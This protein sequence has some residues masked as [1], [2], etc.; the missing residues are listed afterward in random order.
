MTIN[1]KPISIKETKT[2]KKKQ[3]IKASKVF[4][5]KNA[6]GMISYKKKSGS[7]KLSI[8]NTGKITIKKGTKKG[9]YKMKVT[10]TASGNNIYNM[11]AKI[12]TV[13]I[14]VK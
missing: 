8:S 14:K 10:V 9:T 2:K 4:S 6:Q 7:K 5:I 12:I 1:V 3:T 11:D 13:K